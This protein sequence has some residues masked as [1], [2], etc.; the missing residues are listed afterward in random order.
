MARPFQDWVTREVLPTIRKTGSFKM[1]PGEAMPLPVSMADAMRQHASSE[2]SSRQSQ[3]STAPLPGATRA[4]LRSRLPTP[5]RVALRSSAGCSREGRAF[6]RGRPRPL[7][8]R[9]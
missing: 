8:A 7:S 1:E 3:R 5:F 6:G 9:V 4:C 2:C